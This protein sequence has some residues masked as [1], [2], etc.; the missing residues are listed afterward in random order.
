[1]IAT[2]E[3]IARNHRS[4]STVRRRLRLA[5]LLLLG[6]GMA[7]LPPMARADKIALEV[8]RLGHVYAP[9]ERVS[10]SVAGAA[11]EVTWTLTDM[12]GESVRA[13]TT[14]IRAGQGAIV[15]A[16]GRTGWFKL[17]ARDDAGGTAATCFVVIEPPRAAAPTDRFAVMTHFAQGWDLDILPL[18]ARAG[19]GQVRD[20]LYWQ[21]V[22]RTKG[23]FALPDAYAR[24]LGALAEQRLKLLLVLS[25]ANTLY[26]EGNTPYTVTG[27]AAFAAYAEYVVKM[28]GGRLSGVEV[29]NEFNGSFCKGPCE[30]DRPASYAA[31]LAATYP[32]LKRA[33]PALPVGGGAA[34]LVP[35]PWFRALF[36]QGVLA[37]LDAVAIHPYRAEP[38]GVELSLQDLRGLEK[39]DDRGAEKPIWATEIS[40]YDSSPDGGANIA[41]Y[42]VRQ[43]TILLEEGVTR[44]SWYLLRDYANFATM[45]LLAGPDSPLGRYAPAPA[46]AAYATLVR[47]LDRAVPTGR[48]ATDPR[49][50]LYRFMADG[51]ELR[52]GWSSEATAHLSLTVPGPI[53]RIDLMGNATRLTPVDGVVDLTLDGNPVYLKGSVSAIRETQRP[54]LVA[55]SIAGFTGTPGTSSSWSYGAFVCPAQGGGT[56]ACLADYKTAPLQPLSWQ[57]NQWDWA[58][59][60][61]R[62]NSLQVAIDIAHPSAWEGHQVWAVRRWTADAAGEVMLTGTVERPA[63]Q[64]DGSDVL[65]LRDGSPVWRQ[66]LGRAGSPNRQTFA[67]KTAVDVGSRVDFVVTPGAGTNID[68]DATRFTAEITEADR[69]DEPAVRQ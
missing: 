40:R 35:D 47:Q 22:E 69:A 45:G 48:E 65:I 27:R 56:D 4:V 64:G 63:A 26:D 61:P 5:S 23:R 9:G 28:A 18:V 55:D 12:F 10:V 60:S 7:G 31:L 32:V 50:R 38:E 13:G 57:A 43:A 51:D 52:V 2:S 21:E 20:E 3:P 44:I 29:W 39:R 37:N 53:E 68:S 30:K 14:T 6:L 11:K 15:T 62:F 25:F 19:I 58:W 34:V 36:D 1:M 41:R 46:Y 54:K 49:T 8:P 16:P 33:A 59:R 42:L 67:V 24:Y 66:A 17:T